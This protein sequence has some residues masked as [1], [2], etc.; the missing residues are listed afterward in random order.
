MSLKE[1][2]A[3]SHRLVES[4][5]FVKVLFSGEIDPLLYARY[6]YN[7]Y[8]VYDMLETHALM[9]GLLKDLQGI[10]RAPR[11]YEDF[12]EL[13]PKGDEPPKELPSTTVYKQYLTQIRDEPDKLMAHMYVR[14]M[15]DLFGG[16]MI[17]KKVPGEGNYYKF[18]DVDNLKTNIRSKLNDTMS[19]EAMVC[20]SFAS[21]LFDELMYE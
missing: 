8:Q 2:T 16:Q 15:G 17:A 9:A 20:F 10:Q 21:A 6:L 13:W 19:E 12:Y 11:I 4:K 18:E 3:E 14:H 7:Q 5:S 1:L